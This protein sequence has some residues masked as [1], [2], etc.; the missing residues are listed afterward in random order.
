MKHRI[1]VNYH[2]DEKDKSVDWFEK[3]L[4]LNLGKKGK[5]WWSQDVTDY[6]EWNTR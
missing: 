3:Y 2:M 5:A 1:L 4:E 6:W